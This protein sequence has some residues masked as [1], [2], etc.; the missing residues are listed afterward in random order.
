MSLRLFLSAVTDPYE[1]LRSRLAEHLRPGG[2]EV[3]HQREFVEV[4]KNTL[5]KLALFIEHESDVVLHL[6]GSKAGSVPPA[7]VTNVFL[8]HCGEAALRQRFP[9]LFEA[10]AF[11]RLTYT[12]WEAWLGLFYEKHVVVYQADDATGTVEPA[13]TS[14]MPIAEHLAL[15]QPECGYPVKFRDEDELVEYKLVPPLTRILN[16][17]THHQQRPWHLPYSALGE[18]FIG[19]EV[20]LA[21]L[22]R[23]FDEARAAG[24]WPKHAVCGVGGIGKTRVV[25]EYALQH[26]DSYTAV[27]MVNGDSPE[28]LRRELAALAGLFVSNIDPA[29]PEETRERA[30]L[31][32]LQRNPGWL[33]IIDNADT[34]A[35]RDEVAARLVQWSNGHLLITARFARWPH[36]VEALD[37]RVLSVADATRFLLKATDGHRRVTPD[38]ADH[39]RDLARDDLDCLCLALQ[40]A[41]AYIVKREISFA[42]YRRR[43]AENEKEARTWADKVVMEYHKASKASLS[44]ATTWLT[45]F[46]ELTPAARTLLEMLAWLAPD[47]IPRGLFDH[48]QLQTELRTASGVPEADVEEALAEL[49]DYS[50]ISHSQDDLADSAGRVHRILQLITRDRLPAEQRQLTLTAM[51]S[52]V[53]HYTPT[54]SDD[55]RTWPVLDPLR[56]H[57]T[58][59]IAHAEA[60]SIAEPTAR[61]LSVMGTL[62]QTKALFAAAEPLI[63][64]ALAIDEQSYGAK[65]PN[66]ALRLTNLA[67]LLQA[68]NRLA[69][70]EPLMRRALAIDEQSYGAEHPKVAIDLNNL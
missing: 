56:P 37:L 35:A 4:G 10:D 19:R 53:N 58:A 54:E 67:Q 13:G 26:R 6:V 44:V 17:G 36:S 27:L 70:A 38:D 40:Q 34:Q 15:L 20:F 47:P 50:L 46:R 39:A 3:R 5:V 65:H 51:L 49:R 62:L 7:E 1:L 66:V 69:E 55:V 22:R 9:R 33:L 42:E 28:S 30:T 2:F 32:W 64:R 16:Q 59:V 63:R 43:W 11:R 14:P 48:L 41:A 8:R 31:D 61:L 60:A 68:T 23:R 21:E 52:A 57:L 29:V 18:L 24:R 12:Q 25:V 45:T